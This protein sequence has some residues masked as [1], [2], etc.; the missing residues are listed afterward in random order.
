MF[1]KGEYVVYGNTGICQVMDVTTMD[2][3]GFPKDR[4]YY[5][6]RPDGK[7]EGRIF[8]PVSNGKL[9]L[10]RVMTQEEAENLIEEIPEIETLGISGGTVQG[11]HQKL[12]VPGADPYHQDDLYPEKRTDF[13][14][15]E[16]H[17]HR[18]ALSEDR[19]R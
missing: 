15:E 18:R 19:G 9:V 6:L 5:V 16:G 4:L 8:T 13:P 12:R 17:C 10:R 14:G 7:Q 2:M 3:A 11:V 1:E